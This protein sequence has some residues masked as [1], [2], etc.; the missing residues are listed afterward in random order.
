[1]I[2]YGKDAITG[3]N[4]LIDQI[5]GEV[6]PVEILELTNLMKD[7]S[8]NMRGLQKKYHVTDPDMRERIQKEIDGV[9][10]LFQTARSIVD[11]LMEDAINIEQQ[12]D[13]VKSQLSGKEQQMIKNVH[14]YDK[15]Y[16]QNETE[17]MNVIAP[18]AVME[19][20]RDLANTEANTLEAAL[21]F[22]RVNHV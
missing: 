13:R 6:K 3:M 14:L 10:R 16:M 20:V 18:T 4:A 2:D 9:K 22:T 21:A 12:T 15:M 5:L 17:V 11:I 1:M 19:L 8:K 7:L